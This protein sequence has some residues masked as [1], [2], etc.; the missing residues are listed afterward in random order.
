MN[1]LTKAAGITIAAASLFGLSGMAS[2]AQAAEPGTSTTAPSATAVVEPGPGDPGDVAANAYHRGFDITNLSS[3]RLRLEQ[4]SGVDAED[5]LPGVG[6]ILAPGPGAQF[7]DCLAVGKG[8]LGH[9]PVLRAERPGRHHRHLLGHHD[10]QFGA[11]LDRT[12]VQR[13]DHL[14]ADRRAGPVVD[15][16]GIPP[17]AS[18]TFRPATVSGR[19]RC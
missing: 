12:A 6:T 1:V 5:Q 8:S 16:H 10:R 7:P 18:S 9:A 14:R 3:H 19:P 4:L 17:G 13:H 2:A 11:G 15:V